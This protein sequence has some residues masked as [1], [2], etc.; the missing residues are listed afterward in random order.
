MTDDNKNCV[1]NGVECDCYDCPNT[2]CKY[3][4]CECLCSGGDEY[5]ANGKC[6]TKKE[7][8]KND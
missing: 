5:W 3:E 2:K 6:P 8:K 4:E 7:W 1:K